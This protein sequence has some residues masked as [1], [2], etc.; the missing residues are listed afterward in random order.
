MA[1]ATGL[2]ATT[3]VYC[4]IHDSN[5]SLLPHLRSQQP[6]FAVVSTGTWIIS[7]A[8]GGRAVALDPARDTLINVNASGDP[9]PSA[10]F[11]GGREWEVAMRGR[12]AATSAGDERAV[13]E[14]G[15][16]LLPSIEQGSGPFAGRPSSW[17]V[18][19]DAIGSGERAVA[20]SYYLALMT[21]AGLDE[22]GAEGSVMLDGPFARNPQYVG[23][24]EAAV[25]RPVR[26]PATIGT[27]ASIGAAL[28]VS[29][30]LRPDLRTPARAAA[31]TAPSVSALAAYAA[32]WRGRVASPGEAS[33]GRA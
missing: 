20:V 21:A 24:L 14:R 22:I 29:P 5:A 31:R 10:R 2:A 17:T 12:P 30:D 8:I 13:L 4:G 26:V 28:L 11:M 15:I 25:R 7:M 19:E 16:M 23:M 6:P 1:R 9:V 27:G 32:S 3:P 33:P 18:P